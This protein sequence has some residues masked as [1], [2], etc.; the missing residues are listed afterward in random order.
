MRICV[1]IAVF[2]LSVIVVQQVMNYALSYL[3]FEICELGNHLKYNVFSYQSTSVQCKSLLEVSLLSLPQH[4]PT[5]LMQ[6][7][8]LC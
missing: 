4:M 2:A 3:R 6:K 1:I 8:S 7:H 5:A